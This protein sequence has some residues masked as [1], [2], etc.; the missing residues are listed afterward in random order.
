[1]Q[2]L[3]TS[4]AGR[5]WK[6]L[7]HGENEEEEEEKEEEEGIAVARSLLLLLLLLLDESN[8]VSE[9]WE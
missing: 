6:W 4:V 8:K 3:V 7:D 9:M 2:F 1:M 5:G